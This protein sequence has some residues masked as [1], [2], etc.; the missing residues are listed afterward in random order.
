MGGPCSVGL[1]SAS[2]RPWSE[3]SWL[4]KEDGSTWAQGRELERLPLRL[5]EAPGGFVE[6]TPMASK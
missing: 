3:E 5:Q 1:V 4:L 6:A 2:W